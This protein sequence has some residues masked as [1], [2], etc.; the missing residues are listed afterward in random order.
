MQYSILVIVVTLKWR[1]SNITKKF[2]ELF[3]WPW[4]FQFNNIKEV[5]VCGDSWIT[6]TEKCIHF[7]CWLWI[8]LA[9]RLVDVLNSGAVSWSRRMARPVLATQHRL[10]CD[11]GLIKMLT[12]NCTYSRTST[13][14]TV[15]RIPH[16]NW[17]KAETVTA[18][19]PAKQLQIRLS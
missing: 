11:E 1:L 6:R 16:L 7:V 15:V 18:A 4:I 9:V 10:Y 14:G 3:I 12:L 5:V 17:P 2:K 13:Y 19:H 8:Y